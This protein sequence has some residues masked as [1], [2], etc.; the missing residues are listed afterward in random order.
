[1]TTRAPAMSTIRPPP[2]VRRRHLTG[3]PGRRP[4]SARRRSGATSWTA[5]AVMTSRCSRGAARRVLT[6]STIRRGSAPPD[7]GVPQSGTRAVDSYPD[8]MK[9]SAPVRSVGVLTALTV[10]NVVAQR[11][12]LPADI[13]VPVGILALTA[14][15]RAT[16]LPS[17]EMGLGLGTALRGVGTAGLAAAV[18]VAGV[19][20]ATRIPGADGFRADQRYSTPAMARRAALTRIPLAVAIPEEI[21]FRGVLDASLRRH[22]APPA[23]SVWGAVAFGAWH[24]IGATTLGS[25]NDGL[26][27]V[28]GTGRRS[29]AVAVSGAVASTGMAGLGFLALR[30]RSESVLPGIALH[31]ALN[32]SAALAAGLRRPPIG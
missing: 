24:A 20:A 21:A 23:A 26:G 17:D 29:T 19:A 10:V 31:W 12:R 30:R 3:A 22:L 18:T 7:Q 32:G 14:A 9:I 5:R 15:A 13:V 27:R 28:L 4:S 6:R 8:V 1:M 16:G 2:A 25:D 11:S